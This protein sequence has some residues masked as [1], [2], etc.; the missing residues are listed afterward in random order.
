MI[1]AAR[2]FVALNGRL[3]DRHRFAFLFDDGPAE[4]VLRALLAYRTGPLFAHGLE[5]DKRSPM[6]QPIDQAEALDVLAEIGAGQDVARSVC[7]A[8]PR[9]GD[10]GLPFTH[11]SVMDAPH[12]PWWAC[13]GPQ[14][15]SINP[16]GHVLSALY[17]LN[18]NHPWM[19]A[20]E[21]FCW[22]NLPDLLPD[23]AHSCHAATLFLDAHPDRDRARTAFAHVP[24]RA[25][26]QFDGNG[27]G[28]GPLIF[29][30]SPTALAC[31]SYSKIE[32]D[33]ALDQLVA[34]QQSDGGWPICWPPISPMV[35][36]ECRARV[37]I[38]ALKTLRNWRRL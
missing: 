30:P 5:P 23:S 27:Y 9:L 6:P 20:A 21:A 28:L 8:L 34:G 17:R 14:P 2:R 13:D 37:T 3:L 4:P 19:A 16:T 10:V 24:L 31:A 33:Q 26:T 1:D 15:D 11:P 29:A 35:E 18:L 32:L 25:A 36:A 38:T 7:D 12:A 22:A